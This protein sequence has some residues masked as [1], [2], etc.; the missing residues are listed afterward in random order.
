MMITSP[1]L[2]NFPVDNIYALLSTDI[3]DHLD[4]DNNKIITM[5]DYNPFSKGRD[6]NKEQ[7]ST[8]FVKPSTKEDNYKGDGSYRSPY[9]LNKENKAQVLKTIEKLIDHPK[10][11]H[12]V[13]VIFLDGIYEG[14][15]MQLMFRN[16][17]LAY[18]NFFLIKHG[19]NSS[20]KLILRALNHQK[21]V[22][23]GINLMET[24]LK[25]GQ[26]CKRL[27]VALNL[28]GKASND[29]QFYSHNLANNYFQ[30]AYVLSMKFQNYNSG[31]VLSAAENN[32]IKNNHIL[33]I[34]TNKNC[35]PGI[36]AIGINFGSKN[37]LIKN[38]F[39]ENTWNNTSDLDRSYAHLVHPIYQSGGWNNIYINNYIQNSSGSFFKLGQKKRRPD[40]NKRNIAI[41]SDSPNTAILIGNTFIQNKKYNDDFKENPVFEEIFSF[42]H[43]KGSFLY[44]NQLLNQQE[45]CSLSS[46]GLIVIGNTFKNSTLFLPEK[47][48][49]LNMIFLRQD[50]NNEKGC[51]DDI[52]DWVFR[53]NNVENI[54]VKRMFVQR[55]WGQKLSNLKLLD[56][57]VS[58]WKNQ[59]KATIKKPFELINI[60]LTEIKKHTGFTNKGTL[61]SLVI[62]ENSICQSDV[63]LKFI[64][65]GLC[66]EY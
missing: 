8:I 37:N 36:S 22:W 39:I 42:I 1:E 46:S 63:P 50:N 34:G 52:S 58:N 3:P 43:D 30:N 35:T 28:K 56:I 65:K 27:I 18:K 61:K 25:K 54:L 59:F 26:Q 12:N 14:L 49:I 31:I 11:S 17:G 57:A 51:K 48:K 53:N 45:T 19:E 62:S 13:E 5:H 4:Y 60:A 16:K 9:L 41:S 23:N 32:M 44:K 20:A 64:Q 21:A 7:W 66:P 38:N 29:L 2:F 47:E 10:Y 55:E 40:K 33:N 15:Q 6:Y 24:E